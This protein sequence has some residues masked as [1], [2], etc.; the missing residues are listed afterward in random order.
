M[1]YFV[2]GGTGFIGQNL[3][4]L[5]LQRRGTVYVLVRKGSEGKLDKLRAK[6]GKA[7]SR[8]VPITG[9]L[10]KP[11][12]GVRPVDRKKLKGKIN[13]F[14]HLAAIYDLKADAASQEAANV[15]GTRHAVRLASTIE[16]KRF[17]HCSSIAAAGLYPGI[18]TEE[19]FEEAMGLEHAYFRTKHESEGVVR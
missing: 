8:I 18:F 7:A 12:M 13:H 19:M 15:E 2:T 14:F 11:Y 4:E 5:L 3:I 1:S 17:H 16:A 6:A 10:T 9:D